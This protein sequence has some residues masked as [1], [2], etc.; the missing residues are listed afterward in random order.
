VSSDHRF[1]TR[2][3]ADLDEATRRAA[4]AHARAHG[5]DVL[6]LVPRNIP[7]GRAIFFLQAV[8]PRGFK[9]DRSSR[10]VSAGQAIL[11][12]ADVLARMRAEP[13][14]KDSFEF[15]EL[16]QR[17]KLYAPKTMDF[18]VAPGLVASPGRIG[19]ARALFRLTYSDFSIPI[20]YLQLALVLAG[21]FL[22]RVAGLAALAMLNLQAL[23]ITAGTPLRPRGLG[24]YVL[25]RPLLDLVGVLG[26]GD[27]DRPTD[28][29]AATKL[30]PVYATLL[31]PGAVEFFEPPR[32]DCPSCG[33]SPLRRVLH[34]GDM[35]Q[36]KPGRFT[37]DRCTRCGLIFQN[38]RLSV[39]GLSFYYR[40]FYDGLGEA[41]LE[42]V[43]GAGGDSYLAR[44]AM[45]RGHG[46]PKS[47]I[48]V[49]AGHGHFCNTA[50]E[51][52]PTTT[53]DG[54]DFSESI[55][56]AERRGWVA[57]AHRG[58][59]PELAVEL[60]A[61][62]HKYDVVSMSHY[63]E[64]TREPAAE[65]EAAARVLADGGLLLIEVPDPESRWGKLLGRLWFPWFQ[66]QHQNFL[67]AHHVEE[68]FQKHGFQT[69]AW[70]RG[71]AHQPVDV[72]LALVLL[73]HLIAPIPN[74]PWRSPT[75][76]IARTL[77]QLVWWCS[78]PLLLAT[79]LFDRALAPLMRR[80]GW[81]NT[82]RV[83]ARRVSAP[84]PS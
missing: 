44:A 29:E 47:W 42:A 58:L 50:R 12:H 31:G 76:P 2:P 14:P 54:V 45:V 73:L 59:F 80:V 66:P 72:F 78:V 21:P 81:S 62:A 24:L 1:I 25:A 61:R 16:A 63:L 3:G 83:L 9:G 15:C 28:I 43:F 19:E 33:G 51:L 32:T 26:I 41:G 57:H 65:I 4:S 8:D 56:E 39:D 77:C 30:R 23:T 27:R 68:L 69:I 35:I 79:H 46:E 48:D 53:F 5:V 20:I 74:R 10:A 55:E 11:V 17:L 13:A 18:A 84:T 34:S 75:G 49:G 60:A 38:P 64:H 7:A 40:D 70:H 71:E 22:A 52:F 82:M 6:D 37:L 36:R 67:Q